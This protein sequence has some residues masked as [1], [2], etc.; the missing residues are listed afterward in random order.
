MLFL[1]S[2][3]NERSGRAAVR[4]LFTVGKRFVPRA[5]DR[6]RIKRLMREAYRLE[7][8]PLFSLGTSPA[9]GES[10]QLQLAFIY[11]GRVDNVP[12]LGEFR[13]D[14]RRMQNTM[15]S[16]GLAQPLYGGQIE[17]NE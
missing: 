6:N 2:Q 4:A 13:T 16:K 12:P 17:H 15:V 14:I 3:Q 7:K 9:H 11:R 10:A 1:V 8:K 5:V